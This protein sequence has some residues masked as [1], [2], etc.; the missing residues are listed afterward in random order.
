[1]IFARITVDHNTCKLKMY[2]HAYQNNANGDDLVCA[3][4]SV[5]AGTLMGALRNVPDI[6]LIPLNEPGDFLCKSVNIPWYRR[7]EVF[8]IFKTIL[9]GLLQIEKTC[10]SAINISVFDDFHKLG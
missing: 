3:A 6:K 10:P 5:L 9:I 2:G 4:A 1:M 7:K 8:T